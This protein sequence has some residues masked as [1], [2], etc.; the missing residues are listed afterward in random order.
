[1]VDRV[2]DPG[3]AGFV[4]EP[5]LLERLFGVLILVHELFGEGTLKDGDGE[6]VA[7]LHEL[8]DWTLD[9]AGFFDADG[10]RLPRDV[11]RD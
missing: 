8:V 7:R 4:V 6:R 1:M 2:R 5:A 11:A 9:E 10:P 3:C